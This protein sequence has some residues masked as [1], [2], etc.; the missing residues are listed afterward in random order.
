[1]TNQK[2]RKRI[3]EMVE[4]ARDFII[5]ELPKK[6]EECRKEGHKNLIWHDIVIHNQMAS[7]NI[8]TQKGFCSYCMTYDIERSWSKEDW[9]RYND[10]WKSMSEMMGS[11][12]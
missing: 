8:G 9:K 4:R 7:E 2:E 3:E 5:N 1:M 10:F 11:Y 12:L 6:R